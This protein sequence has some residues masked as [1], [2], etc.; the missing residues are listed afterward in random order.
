MKTITLYTRSYCP[1]C[2]M[3]KNLLAQVGAA[4]RIHEISLD[5][6][7]AAFDEMR[8]KSGRRTVP[9]IFIG[10]VHVGGFTDLQQLHR[11]GGLMPLLD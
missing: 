11:E 7:D 2:T 6:N 4:E 3:A 8:E 9:Q 1:Y 5:G 10:N